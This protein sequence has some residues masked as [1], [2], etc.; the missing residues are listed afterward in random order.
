M[1]I[2]FIITSI[3]CMIYNNFGACGHKVS[4]ISLGT[5]GM[6]QPGNEETDTEIVKF[7]FESGINFFD[8]AEVYGG[9]KSE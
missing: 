7:A 5:A 4:A 3:S 8:S 6:W 1:I 2:R 9:G